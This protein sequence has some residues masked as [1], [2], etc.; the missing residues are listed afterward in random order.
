MK[1]EKMSWR[2]KAVKLLAEW[3]RTQ[4][5]TETVYKHLLKQVNTMNPNEEMDG[6]DTSA[7]LAALESLVSNSA[8]QKVRL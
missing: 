3:P 2:P 4:Q 8:A 5:R 1:F 6:K 7:Y